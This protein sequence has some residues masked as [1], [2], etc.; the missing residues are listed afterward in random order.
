MLNRLGRLRYGLNRLSWLGRC[1]NWL[2]SNG[3]RLNCRLSRID[4]GLLRQRLLGRLNR[5][6]DISRLN[7][8]TGHDILTIGNI[9]LADVLSLR[10]VSRLDILTVDDVRLA[11]YRLDRCIRLLN[12]LARIDIGL[13]R[14]RLLGRL[15]RLARIDIGLL[16]QRLL[17]RLNRLSRLFGGLLNRVGHDRLSRCFSGRNAIYIVFHAF[18]LL[19]DW[20]A[21][22][23]RYT[24]VGIQGTEKIFMFLK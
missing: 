22:L 12:R 15:N 5:L 1:F 4:I 11:Y 21:F 23:R 6:T 24:E 13:L 8:L 3:Y 7:K 10:N 18:A 20:F 19:V 2:S 14:Q 16:R 17:G 9:R